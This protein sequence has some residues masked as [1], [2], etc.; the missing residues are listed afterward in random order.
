MH[1]AA[2][3]LDPD[4]LRFA[5][6]RHVLRHY[7]ERHDALVQHLVV[8]EIVQQGARHDVEVVGQEHRRAGDAR[9]WLALQ[10]GEQ[11]WK[12]GSF[13]IE[14]MEATHRKTPE[15]QSGCLVCLASRSTRSCSVSTAW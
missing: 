15:G 1:V 14:A 5:D 2:E 11:R 6:A 4:A 9:R 8:L 12:G 13:P 3:M 7:P 10:A